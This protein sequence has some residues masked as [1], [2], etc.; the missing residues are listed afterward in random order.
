MEVGDWITL[1]AVIVALGLGVAAILQTQSLQKR[2]RR[3]RL[4][5]EIID[6]AL[7]TLNCFLTT[8]ISDLP[9]LELSTKDFSSMKNHQTLTIGNMQHEFEKVYNRG[10]YIQKKAA[11]FNSDLRGAIDE[12][13][14]AVDEN[15][16]FCD[17]YRLSF[18]KPNNL[19][20][21]IS[22]L[23]EWEKQSDALCSKTVH[24]VYRITDEIAKIETKDL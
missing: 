3:E 10:R 4:L 22:M 24:I 18:N 7:S 13:K 15:E 1:A 19:D 5:N 17:K 20:E 9:T 11:I 14:K 8:A 12:L 6:W 21:F 2:E 16:S 23:K